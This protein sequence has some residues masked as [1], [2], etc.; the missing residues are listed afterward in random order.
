MEFHDVRFLLGREF[1]PDLADLPWFTP[2][3][4]W[5]SGDIK[6][7]DI[8]R[9]I[10]RHPVRFVKRKKYSYAIKQTSESAAET[11]MQNYFKLLQLGIHTLTPVGT[12]IVSKPPIEVQTKVSTEYEK[13]E[14]SFIVTVLEENA[15]P[16]SY[17]FKLKFTADN[18]RMILSAIAELFAQLHARNIF[19]GDASLANMLVR[20]VKIKD[21][22]GR[23]KTVLK[24]VLAD[25]ETVKILPEISY[26]LVQQDINYF[27]E[28]MEWM[29]EDFLASG[30]VKEPQS[31][32]LDKEFLW[33]YYNTFSLKLYRLRRFEKDTGLDIRKHFG[34]IQNMV[35]LEYLI[36]Q[37]DEHKWYMSE[38]SGDEVP[39]EEAAKNW[40]ETIYKPIIA[41]FEKMHIFDYFPFQ[42]A[43]G[44]Y[45]EIMTH[46]YHM[47]MQQKSD[48]SIN[49]AIADYSSKF[50]DSPEKPHSSFFKKISEIL[51]RM[52]VPV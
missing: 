22:K 30:I 29:A 44:L 51:H 43:T 52:L 17:L 31:M 16:D 27:L 49:E 3:E 8:R 9:G 40:M 41:E 42:T 26:Q 2:L 24:A 6:F 38:K 36:D 46:K 10:S 18:R 23:T 50:A 32:E 14:L 37:I 13:D 34:T 20:F 21:E 33:D 39:L 11:E 7:L 48:I 28:T 25:A 15:L 12:V 1:Y 5:E 35:T 4:E 45:L 47:G 19:W